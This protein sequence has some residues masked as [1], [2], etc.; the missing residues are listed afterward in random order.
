MSSRPAVAPAL[1]DCSEAAAGPGPLTASSRTFVARAT[2]W[3]GQAEPLP[4]CRPEPTPSRLSQDG[5]L[6]IAATQVLSV[7][8]PIRRARRQPRLRAETARVTSGRWAQYSSD[9]TAS[10]TISGVE[11]AVDLPV[12]PVIGAESSGRP[13]RRRMPRGQLAS[14]QAEPGAQRVP[15][16][17]PELGAPA[18]LPRLARDRQLLDAMDGEHRSSDPGWRGRRRRRRAVD[19]ELRL[20]P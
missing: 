5:D 16:H 17:T 9:A 6:W 13:R 8:W 4:V 3:E 10:S 12:T 20:V 11:T 19:V 7:G 18:R 14:T 1:T 15:S 2:S